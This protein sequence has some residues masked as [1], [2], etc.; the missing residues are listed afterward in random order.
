MNKIIGLLII[1]SCLS[2]SAH[3]DITVKHVKTDIAN[4][5]LIKD[6]TLP[7]ISVKVTFKHAG[8]ITDPQNLLGRGRI[9]HAA[10]MEGAGDLDARRFAEK[11]DFHA[12]KLGSS[13]G[14]DHASISLT[15]LTEHK[16]TAFELLGAMIISPRYNNEDVQRIKDEYIS[17]IKQLKEK[18]SYLLSQAFKRHGFGEHAYGR[19]YYGDEASINRISPKD[20]HAYNQKFFARDNMIISVSGDITP[21]DL[22]KLL[23]KYLSELPD[24]SQKQDIQQVVLNTNH[25]TIYVNAP[26][27]QTS[28]QISIPGIARS[29]KQFYAAYV[30]NHILGGSGLAARLGKAIRQERGLTYSV[31]SYLSMNDAAQWIGI[32]FSTQNA[33]AKEAVDVAYDVINRAGE[34][35]FSEAELN[36]AKSNIT[37]SFPLNLDSNAERVSYL[38]IMQLHNLGLDYLTKRNSYIES[39]TLEDVNKVA[40][41]YLQTKNHLTLLVGNTKEH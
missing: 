29:D 39:V 25:D 19:D 8:V 15:T 30:M 1:F 27:P 5:W 18:P 21:D 24:T 16:N 32:N 33:T 2:F 13:I 28:V 17:N 9:A 31:G 41:Q 3:A 6:T 37:G 10:M 23:N 12:I 20:L 7:I 40:A 38:D 36:D 14:L 26:Y 4:A 34:K 11:L 22:R 35:G